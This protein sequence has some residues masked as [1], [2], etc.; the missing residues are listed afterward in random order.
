MFAESGRG[1]FIPCVLVWKEDWSQARQLRKG[2]EIQLEKS[3]S[4]SLHQGGKPCSYSPIRTPAPV[5][6]LYEIGNFLRLLLLPGLSESFFWDCQPYV[7]GKGLWSPRSFL[8]SPNHLSGCSY[9]Y[10]ANLKNR[11]STGQDQLY[12]FSSLLLLLHP[13]TECGI[14]DGPGFHL[15]SPLSNS[16]G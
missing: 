14:C 11:G 6:L 7:T 13:L 9:E 3:I 5:Q 12:F 8:D 15:S 1:P 4:Y 2:E 16:A 10:A